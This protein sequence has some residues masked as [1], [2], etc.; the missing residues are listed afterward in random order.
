MKEITHLM[1]VGDNIAMANA[2]H[3]TRAS[4]STKR[5]ESGSGLHN[6]HNSLSPNSLFS[7]EKS[8]VSRR[9][10]L[11]HKLPNAENSLVKDELGL[12]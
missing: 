10:S 2:T 1:K 7:A 9:F 6:L 5:L 3:S 11:N 8:S 4:V 12:V